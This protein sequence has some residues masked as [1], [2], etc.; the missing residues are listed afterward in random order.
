MRILSHSLYL[1]SQQS[2]MQQGLP[3]NPDSLQ[4]RQL[5]DGVPAALE[6]KRSH[7]GWGMAPSHNIKTF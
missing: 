6:L 5:A 2:N 7:D 3:H 1:V 4:S